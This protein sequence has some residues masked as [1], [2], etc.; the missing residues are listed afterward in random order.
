MADAYTPVVANITAEN[1]HKKL[2]LAS[3]SYEYPI[4]HAGYVRAEA[5]CPKQIV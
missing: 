1:L 5:P 4:I 2:Q 3:M